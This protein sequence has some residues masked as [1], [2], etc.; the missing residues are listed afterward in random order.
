[1]FGRYEVLGHKRVLNLE[2]E[3]VVDSR[4]KKNLKNHK[5]QK[6]GVLHFSLAV[7]LSEKF[8]GPLL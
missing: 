1:M 6:C 8:T 4:I 3:E 7:T 5:P 2:K